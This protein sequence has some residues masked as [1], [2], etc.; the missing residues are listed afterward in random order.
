M[1]TGT[2]LDLTSFGALLSAIGW[3][4]W[5]FA[6]AALGAAVYWPK[7]P[8]IKATLAL[9]A[10]A[11]FGYLP[12][13]Y[14]LR[15][16][17]AEQRQRVAYTHF[18]MLCKEAGVRV[19]RPGKGIEGVYLV[20]IRPD[21]VSSHDQ[22]TPDDVYGHDA[23]G[24][25]YIKTFLRVT[26]G[27]NTKTNQFGEVPNI[28]KAGYRWVE[29]H[30]ANDKR[31]Y[32]YTLAYKAVQIKS[33]D[34]WAAVKKNYPDGTRENYDVVLEKKLVANTAARYSVNW[35]DI[36]T[37]DDREHW[38]AGGVVQIV[39]LETKETVAERKGFMWDKGMGSLA[40]HRSPWLFAKD[41][42]CPPFRP[43]E[44]GRAYWTSQFTWSALEPLP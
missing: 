14:V 17:T 22:F 24:A 40:G 3:V 28:P 10:I 7:R 31:L 4:Y 42:V 23:G 33:D 44:E 21:G 37:R 9:V 18:Q 35:V 2:P 11:A 36:S 29:A 34:E 6:L 16:Q 25:E 39:D 27:A 32:R 1:N 5:I 30:D 19:A 8:A 15:I 43:T 41:T 38:I 20:K 26:E 13:S 12:A